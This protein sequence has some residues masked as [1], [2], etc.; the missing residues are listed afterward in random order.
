MRASTLKG[1][2]PELA[3]KAEHAG[4]MR[5]W[6][7]AGRGA[8]PFSFR[9]RLIPVLKPGAESTLPEKSPSI[10]RTFMDLGQ[11]ARQAFVPTIRA[12]RNIGAGLLLLV[13]GLPSS[14]EL[15]RSST[16][17]RARLRKA[18]SW[19]TEAQGIFALEG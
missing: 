9:R 1:D 11:G 2:G 10:T 15:L 18:A 19:R 3:V 13:G 14:D 4:A 16:L 12:F 7:R 8:A 17:A 6:G 5:G